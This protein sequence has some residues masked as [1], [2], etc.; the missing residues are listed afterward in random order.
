MNPDLH[1]ILVA[2]RC[3]LFHP[4]PGDVGIH[5]GEVLSPGKY[6]W[7]L[8]PLLQ[9]LDQVAKAEGLGIDLNTLRIQDQDILFEGSYSIETPNGTVTFY[10]QGGRLV[11]IAFADDVCL[12]AE[13]MEGAQTLMNAAQEYYVSASATL[14]AP[15]SIYTSNRRRQPWE[16][17]DREQLIAAVETCMSSK[18]V[19]QNSD[20]L[21]PIAVDSVL[22]IIDV[23][24]ATNVDLRNIRMV[25]QLGGTIDDTELVSGLV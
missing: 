18:L 8:D 1:P 14:C 22:G 20:I 10:L 2:P 25:T 19:G 9:Y 21:A 17:T 24:T 16:M 12:L 23:A 5:Q 7:S 3:P 13:D 4:K 15:K 11:A 6:G